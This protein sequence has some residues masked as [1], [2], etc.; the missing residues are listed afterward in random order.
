[1]RHQHKYVAAKS[2]CPKIDTLGKPAVIWKDLTVLT[3]NSTLIPLF[4]ARIRSSETSGM[5]HNIPLTCEEDLHVKPREI[6][7]GYL[8][9]QPELH[10][11]H[12]ISLI[13]IKVSWCNEQFSKQILYWPYNQANTIFFVYVDET[14]IYIE[15]LCSRLQLLL[16]FTKCQ[17]FLG[18][19][20]TFLLSAIDFCVC[21][22]K[23]FRYLLARVIQNC[24]SV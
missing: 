8:N 13:R 12:L 15:L 19:P 22:F 7:R 23:Y 1:M 2:G 4:L 11:S 5:R 14:Q 3:L 10:C 17:F 6:P 16:K 21:N 24:A 9:A 18:K 20:N